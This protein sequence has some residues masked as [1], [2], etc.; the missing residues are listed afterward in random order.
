MP[1]NA[2]PRRTGRLPQRGPARS[3]G[4]FSS[5]LKSRSGRTSQSRRPP[6]MRS[7]SG[8]GS[9]SRFPSPSRGRSQ[10]R[11]TPPGRKRQSKSSGLGGLLKSI[12]SSGS[13]G[14]RR[15]SSG[16]GP[17]RKSMF[18]LIAGVGAAAFANRDKLRGAVE[19]RRGGSEETATAGQE[20][21]DSAAAPQPVTDLPG[22]SALAG[23]G[24]SESPLAG[25]RTGDVSPAETAEPVIPPADR[26]DR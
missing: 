19:R 23:E 8:T 11:F 6:S 26:K 3:S 4:R 15:G 22:T 18:A 20:S 1:P 5:P 7:R 13:T 25:G 14:K 12:T 10:P 17:G 21:F 24:A 9:A 16:G 2:Q